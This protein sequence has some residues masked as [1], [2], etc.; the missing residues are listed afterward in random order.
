MKAHLSFE[1]SKSMAHLSLEFLGPAIA[2]ASHEKGYVI[3][4]VQPQVA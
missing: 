1:K 4:V 2:H 3:T